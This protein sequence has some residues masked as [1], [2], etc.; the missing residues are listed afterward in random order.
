MI[1]SSLGMAEVRVRIFVALAAVSIAA[2]RQ[3]GRSA[4]ERYR[5]GPNSSQAA[6]RAS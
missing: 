2:S 6:A 3:Q 5:R 4:G 1:A